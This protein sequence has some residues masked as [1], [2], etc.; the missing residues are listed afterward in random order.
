M[1]NKNVKFAVKCNP[2]RLY[3]I[4]TS[5]LYCLGVSQAHKAKDLEDERPQ[6]RA[7]RS[8]FSSVACHF[9]RSCADH[10]RVFLTVILNFNISRV[11][12]S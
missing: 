7:S 12:A 1:V 5:R 2:V 9:S 11:S 8:L 3:N 4:K 6:L 10:E